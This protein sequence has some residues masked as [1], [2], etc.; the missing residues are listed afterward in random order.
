LKHDLAYE[1]K[2]CFDLLPPS[3]KTDVERGRWRFCEKEFLA[4]VEDGL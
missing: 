1:M 3:L 2:Q 4:V